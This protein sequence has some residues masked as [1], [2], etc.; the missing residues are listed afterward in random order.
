MCRQLANESG[1]GDPV[2]IQSKIILCVDDNDFL[3]DTLQNYLRT[4]GFRVIAC[5][6]G[7]VA[8]MLLASGP[9]DAVVVD[10]EMP[11]MN[12]GDLATAIRLRS[13]FIPIVM[14]SGSVDLPASTLENVDGFVEKHSGLSSVGRMLE[15]LLSGS[16]SIN[17]LP[18]FLN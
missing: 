17:S 5:S 15:S 10:Y 12:G 6:N 16:D 14:F 2:S 9:V 11:N 18:Y 4:K 13:P 8:L 7:E 1:R 3:L